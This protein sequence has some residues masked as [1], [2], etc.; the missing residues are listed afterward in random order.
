LT[1]GTAIVIGSALSTSDPRLT[2]K[3]GVVLAAAGMSISGLSL[4]ASIVRALREEAQALAQRGVNER[5]KDV[6]AS[7][8]FLEDVADD[9]ELVDFCDEL[10]M[11]EIVSSLEEIYATTINGLEDWD[12]LSSSDVTTVGDL[13]ALVRPQLT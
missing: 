13:I 8:C 12:S 9:M 7:Q 2:A 5:V 4:P 11:I 6:V 1:V 10:D 3:G